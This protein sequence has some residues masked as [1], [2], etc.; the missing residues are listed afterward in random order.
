MNYNC[1][2]DLFNVVYVGAE[3]FQYGARSAGTRFIAG[4]D[5]RID[6]RRRL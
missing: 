1:R 6:I 3:M 2:F 5:L 4:A